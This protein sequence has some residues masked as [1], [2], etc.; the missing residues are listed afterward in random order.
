MSIPADPTIQLTGSRTVAVQIDFPDVP[1]H[2]CEQILEEMATS[3]EGTGNGTAI[4]TRSIDD[5]GN[6]IETS[7]NSKIFG[8]YVKR[9]RLN[10]PRGTKRA[11]ASTSRAVASKRRKVVLL[12]KDAAKRSISDLIATATQLLTKAGFL[13]LSVYIRRNTNWKPPRG[14]LYHVQ[15]PAPIGL[16]AGMSNG[17]KSGTLY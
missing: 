2:E 10:L 8:S 13:T 5:F 4:I 15:D 1:T 9:R 14:S 16:Y 3:A 11:T 7:E 12:L 17:D 6:F